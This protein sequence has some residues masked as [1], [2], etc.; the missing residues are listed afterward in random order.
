MVRETS[1]AKATCPPLSHSACEDAVA[2]D[3]GAGH[4]DGVIVPSEVRSKG[5][6]ARFRV[7]S[8]YGGGLNRSM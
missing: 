8:D 7:T 1:F 5:L 2:A 4:Q 6:Q 3:S